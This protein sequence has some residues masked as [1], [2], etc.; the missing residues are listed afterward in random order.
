MKKLNVP[1]YLLRTKWFV[2]FLVAVFLIIFGRMVETP[3]LSK[4]AVVLGLG[5][6]YDESASLFEVSTQAVLVGSSSGDTTETSYVCTSAKGNTI[7]GAMDAIARKIGLTVSLSHCNV[8]FMSTSAFKLD[9]MQLIYPLTGMYAL[10]EQTIIVT[11][12]KSPSEML[13]LRIGTTLSS[14]FFLQQALVNEEGSD[15]MIRTTAKD[16]LARSLSRSKANV[17]PYI[18]A[19][20]ATPPLT[21]AGSEDDVYELDISRA[22]AFDNENYCIIENEYA[23][24]LAL[25]HSHDVTGTLNYTAHDGGTIEFK[26]LKKSVKIKAYGRKVIAEI[27]LSA[28]FADVQ[29]IPTDEVV[30]TDN[31][32][33]KRYAAALAKDIEKRLFELYEL[34]VSKNIDFLSLQAKA[35]QSVGR[36][37]EEDCLVTLSFEPKVS[38]TVKEAG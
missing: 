29:K 11:G 38:I 18:I 34:S 3:S 2:F 4:S 32:I 27:K 22:M 7:A 17:I 12:D 36:N 13:S 33:V 28:D 10:P 20:K 25:Y 6:D 30:N 19:K 9:H 26:I 8:V 31:E 15:G 23:E 1:S 37:L 16:F 5:I 14:P 21:E 35:Y 24:I